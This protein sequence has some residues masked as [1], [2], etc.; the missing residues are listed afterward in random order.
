MPN[1]FR[2]WDAGMILHAWLPW[3]GKM[4]EK[5]YHIGVVPGKIVMIKQT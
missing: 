2:V 1:N 5:N 4:K 3:E